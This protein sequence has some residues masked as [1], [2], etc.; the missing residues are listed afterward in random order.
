MTSSAS[1]PPP[2]RRI[3]PGRLASLAARLGDR[4]RQIIETLKLVRV[5][6]A[7]QLQRLWFTDASPRSNARMAQRTLKQL[8]ALRVVTRLDRTPGGTGGGSA[9]HVYALDVAGL[10]LTGPVNTK[11]VRRP[12]PVSRLF[13]D[14]ALEITEWYVRLVEE[15]RAGGLNVLEYRA[16]PRRLY[17]TGLGGQTWLKPDAFVRLGN[18]E[19]EEHW[20]VEVDRD[21]EHVPALRRKLDQYVAYWRTGIEQARNEVFPQVLWIVPNVRRYDELI[22]EF[23]RLPETVWPLFKVALRDRA[24]SSISSNK[25]P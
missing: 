16:E 21:T 25:P 10:R 2:G 4:D 22:D 8:A 19:W 17:P 15:E 18:N 24:I 23:G 11:V 9:G 20:F 7:R 5:A 3:T 1:S 13:L 14:H 6:T 12:W